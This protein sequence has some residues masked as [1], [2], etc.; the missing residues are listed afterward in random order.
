M[1]ELQKEKQLPIELYMSYD[2]LPL[3]QQAKILES[4]SSIYETILETGFNNFPPYLRLHYLLID[5]HYYPP[6]PPLCIH[7]AN[8]GESINLKFDVDNNVLPKFV[9]HNGDLDVLVPQ[10]TAAAFITGS[11][12]I[13]GLHGYKEILEIQKLNHELE[14]IETDKLEQTPVSN[15]IDIHLNQ[16]NY[17]IN[18]NNINRVMIN[19]HSVKGDN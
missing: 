4:I 14:Q 5:N 19:N 17:E 13:G 8:T 16:F 10:W 11:L 12:L 3:K 9:F 6:Y 2:Y 15:K 1:Q 7:S 18:Q